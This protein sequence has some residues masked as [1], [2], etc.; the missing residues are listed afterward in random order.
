MNLQAMVDTAHLAHGIRSSLDTQLQAAFAL[1]N[2]GDTTDGVSQL[3][4]F[5][6]HVSAQRGHQIPADLADALIAYAQRII[7]A[8]G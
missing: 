6:N 2:Q 1:F 5:I 7:H 3:G 4:A 8:V